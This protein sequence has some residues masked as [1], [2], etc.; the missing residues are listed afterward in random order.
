MFILTLI[1]ISWHKPIRLFFLGGSLLSKL[2]CSFNLISMD[3]RGSNLSDSFAETFSSSSLS[4]S[5]CGVMNDFKN[6]I[7]KLKIQ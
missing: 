4:D 3:E 6:R 1:I 7:K 5:P 2:N